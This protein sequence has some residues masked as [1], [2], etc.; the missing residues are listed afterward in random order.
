MDV[1]VLNAGTDTW[2]V[3]FED[4]AIMN[5]TR[6]EHVRDAAA[7]MGR[8]FDV[9]GLRSFADFTSPNMWI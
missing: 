3:E 8:Y 7:V 1:Q 9:M 2:G 5:G 4:G 6:P